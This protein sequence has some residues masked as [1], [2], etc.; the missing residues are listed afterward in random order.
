MSYQYQFNFTFA[1]GKD[2]PK[3]KDDREEL[4]FQFDEEAMDFPAVKQNKF[5]DKVDDESDYEL[6]DGEI[7]KLLIITPS[8]PKK[9]EG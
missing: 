5:S 8:R 3:M 2:E 4:D 1:I 9:H 7:N 6:S